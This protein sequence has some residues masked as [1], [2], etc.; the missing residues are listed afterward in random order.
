MA[1]A[2]VRALVQCCV[3][4][5]FSLPPAPS[6][7]QSPPDRA[8]AEQALGQAERAP[9]LPL[10]LAVSAITL[11]ER[12]V[13]KILCYH[14]S[15][16]DLRSRGI[17]TPFSAF[18]SLS[19]FARFH[20]QWC[21][22]CTYDMTSYSSQLCSCHANAETCAP[23]LVSC[24][25]EGRRGGTHPQESQPTALSLLH[26]FSRSSRLVHPYTLS[27]SHL[28]SH[29]Y[30]HRLNIMVSFSPLVLLA[31]GATLASASASSNCTKGADQEIL[32]FNGTQY[33][34][35]HKQEVSGHLHFICNGRSDV[36]DG[37]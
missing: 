31:L 30:S 23:E 11:V 33:A 10:L 37:S 27:L 9:L 26:L 7:D 4:V 2:G 5:A 12:A 28:H 6:L 8:C 15:G 29:S 34:R 18:L 1:I 32:H 25:G 19:P 20:A 3:I 21:N 24:G 14:C 16:V 13:C 35:K 17:V 36:G 22:I